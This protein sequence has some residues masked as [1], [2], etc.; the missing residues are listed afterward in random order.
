MPRVG[1]A[2][3]LI[4]RAA[5]LDM[6]RGTLESAIDGTAGAVLLAGEA[7]VGKTRVLRELAELTTERGGLVLTGRCLDV[8]ESGM[9]YLPFAEA[10]GRLGTVEPDVVAT[11][12]AL[13][14]LAPGIEPPEAQG[15]APVLV[16]PGG[17][18]VEQ[19]VGQLRLYDAVLGALTEVAARRPVLL[20]IEDVHW[21]ESSTLHLLS[22]LIAR[23][24]AQRL[25]VVATYRTDELHRRHPL[26]PVLA[27]LVRDKAVLRVD[28][29]PL[30]ERHSTALVREL[31][32]EAGIEPNGTLLRDIAARCEG[33]AFF[34]EELI[35]AAGT[36]QGQLPWA[37]ADVLLSRVEQLSAET[38]ELLRIAAVGG[39]WVRHRRL[40]A[41]TE[42]GGHTEAGLDGALREAIGHH[43]LVVD[44]DQDRYSFRHALLRE[45]VYGDLLPGE[46]ARLHGHYVAAIKKEKGKGV[47]AALAHHALESDT[48]PEALAALVDAVDEA[49]RLGAPS[50]A[51]RHAERALRVWPKVPADQRPEAVTE[52]GLLRE[53]SALCGSIG[54]PER[55]IRYA[56][57]AVRAAEP[58][59]DPVDL[60]RALRRVAESVV[61]LDDPGKQPFEAIDRAWQLL[62]NTEAYRDKASVL[63]TRSILL[64][65]VDMTAA[66]EAAVQAIAA[67]EKAGYAPGKANALITLGTV[68][69][70]SGHPE[71]AREHYLEAARIAAE[72][73]APNAELRARHML[74]FQAFEVGELDAAIT[75]LEATLARAGEY[76]LT[77]SVFGVECRIQLAAA[78]F[79]AGF[80]D[81]SLEITQSSGRALDDVVSARLTAMSLPV[82]VERGRF[83]E[84]ERMLEEIRDKWQLDWQVP[85]WAATC[86]AALRSWRG[87]HRGAVHAIDAMLAFFVSV[88]KPLASGGIRAAALAL[89]AIGDAGGTEAA[90]LARDKD[91]QLL[92]H[93]ERIDAEHSLGIEAKAWLAAVHAEYAAATGAPDAA[94]KFAAAVEAFGYGEVHSQATYRL[95]YA[96]V[97]LDAGERERAGVQLRKARE[98]AERLGAA[99]LGEA[100]E[101]LIKRARLGSPGGRESGLTEREQAVLELVAEG[102]TNREV[103]LAL[104]ISEKTVSVHLSR[105]MAKL[106]ATRRTEAVAVAYDRGL[107]HR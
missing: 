43:L 55:A 61:S 79:Q 67:A 3:P 51:L 62:E 102:K 17:R 106:G 12:P 33:N 16:P 104:F 21:A 98:V 56:R 103:G 14:P 68:E 13:I 49:E 24:Q 71:Q 80:W 83:T 63:A 82:F 95:R 47:A 84:A 100:V 58:G 9:P 32:K 59:T 44:G 2:L 45:A 41:V 1:N 69:A 30:S 4:G 96:R 94:E 34:A 75:E 5:E 18:R 90:G 85:V 74:G 81:R 40:V 8:G 99:P 50:E 107:L 27:E 64:R 78:L 91:R 97:L 93:A 70:R 15:S 10:L 101:D 66:G 39:R 29:G 38:Q 23:L 48:L 60:A 19:D 26:R 7:G 28:L 25:F 57:Q 53:A 31:A 105:T 88:G 72:S 92:E 35:A 42:E 37:L 73:E 54:Q 20:A 77:F 65:R 46:R 89:G 86:E 11:R 76:G 6:L 22:F 36:G 52:S 87:D